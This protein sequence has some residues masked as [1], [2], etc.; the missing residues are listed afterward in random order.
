MVDGNLVIYKCGMPSVLKNAVTNS[1]I[2]I[3]RL[4]LSEDKSV[5]LHIENKSKCK[6]PCSKLKVYDNDM[7]KVD[8]VCYLGNKISASGALR[9]CVDDRRNKG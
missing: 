6:M 8:S 3:E 4:I 1:F 9:P 5:V 7:K 2:K